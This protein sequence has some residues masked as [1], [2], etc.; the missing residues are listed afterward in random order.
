MSSTINVQHALVKRL[1]EILADINVGETGKERPFQVFRHK[2][3]EKTI[4]T[5]AEYDYS[6]DR[7]NDELYPFCVVRI[8]VGSKAA[9][10]EM[11]SSRFQLLIGVEN[12]GKEGQGVDDVMTC[13]EAIW[14]SLNE[15]PILDKRYK[16]QYPSDFAVA[17]DDH[18]PFYYAGMQL[19]FEHL[20]MMDFKNTDF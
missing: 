6:D 2:L 18:H 14:Q 12:N 20:A 8:D 17:S 16:L 9:N 3:P 19:D 7:G 11:Q 13:V 10:H 5:K 4:Q 1:K 15:T